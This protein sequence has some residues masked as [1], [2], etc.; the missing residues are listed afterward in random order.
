MQSPGSACRRTQLSPAAQTR[1]IHTPYE[2]QVNHDSCTRDSKFQFSNSATRFS[3]TNACYPRRSASLGALS[4]AIKQFQCNENPNVPFG[5]P[6]PMY[7][8]SSIQTFCLQYQCQWPITPNAKIYETVPS[9]G[10]VFDKRVSGHF[11]RDSMGWMGRRRTC[12][13]LLRLPG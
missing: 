13:V 11:R 8:R 4:V 1:T 9:M 3:I 6:C 5:K 7:T 12:E 10:V 2:E